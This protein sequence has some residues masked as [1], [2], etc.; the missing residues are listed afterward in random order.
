M[1][2]PAV[3]GAVWVSPAPSSA[4]V[5]HRPGPG[6]GTLSWRC[7][8]PSCC[9][10]CAFC[11]CPGDSLPSA[12]G[13]CGSPQ[14]PLGNAHPGLGS[15]C[16]FPGLLLSVRVPV[17]WSP[18]GRALGNQAGAVA[19]R[20]CRP[21][22][23]VSSGSAVRTHWELTEALQARG[24][25][26]AAEAAA[27]L[28]GLLTRVCVG[29]WAP[30]ALCPRM[31]TQH[32]VTPT[33]GL[34]HL[35]GTAPCL[36]VGQPSPSPTQPS[37]DSL[38]RSF[39][40]EWETPPR[41]PLRLLPALL[42]L[43]L[44]CRCWGEPRALRRLDRALLRSV[45]SPLALSPDRLWLGCQAPPASAAA[46]RA[47][48]AILSL[49]LVPGHTGAVLLVIPSSVR[50]GLLPAHSEAWRESWAWPAW[51]LERTLRG[52]GTCALQGRLQGLAAPGPDPR[53]QT[54][55][56]SAHAACSGPWPHTLATCGLGL[57]G[58]GITASTPGGTGKVT[59]ALAWLSPEGSG[60]APQCWGACL[61]QPHL[62]AQ[63][64]GS[65]ASLAGCW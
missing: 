11:P 47:V 39:P 31:P 22:R 15:S 49:P 44:L 40:E 9:G 26:R 34:P 46:C 36:G 53:L 7:P 13:L 60:E 1:Q 14:Q 58:G 2:L 38:S 18:G 24:R 48:G 5:W 3:R 37:A 17:H 65:E 61:G 57:R 33:P 41:Q 29:S 10:S 45:A 8:Q 59:S 30:H 23:G 16:A 56:F 4:R 55:V 28:S 21:A 20:W 54:V 51:S 43:S 12:P 27:W 50:L 63:T 6:S 32:C 62:E 64:R 19:L 42:R 25:A 35:S 52:A